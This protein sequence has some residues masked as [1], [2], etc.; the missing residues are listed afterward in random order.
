MF[1]PSLCSLQLVMD[2]WRTPQCYGLLSSIS[3]VYL[4]WNISKNTKKN[5]LELFELFT[6]QIEFRGQTTCHIDPP[7]YLNWKMI[8][9]FPCDDKKN[10]VVG[11]WSTY[12]Q[13]AYFLLPYPICQ[14]GHI[15]PWC[16]YYNTMVCSK[17][18]KYVVLH[19]MYIMY[20]SLS[21]SLK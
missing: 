15:S 6:K 18:K 14:L 4:L 10:V 7:E 21:M 1:L 17:G 12:D 8:E 16:H 5:L 19:Y 20:F 9:F 11:F 2:C 3:V 13:K